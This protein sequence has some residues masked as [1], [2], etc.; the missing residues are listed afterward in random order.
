LLGGRLTFST[1]MREE[2]GKQKLTG[3]VG[4]S[5]RRDEPGKAGGKEGQNVEEKHPS[6]KKS[7]K[8]KSDEKDSKIFFRNERLFVKMPRKKKKVR[9]NKGDLLGL[10]GRWQGSAF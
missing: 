10:K 1:E 6:R 7:S 4:G 5:E 9:A 3:G 8:R 2:K